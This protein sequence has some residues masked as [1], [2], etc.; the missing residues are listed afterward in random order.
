MSGA[1]QVWMRN[2]ANYEDQV[3]SALLRRGPC[4]S[5]SWQS[6][7]RNDTSNFPRDSGN[8]DFTVKESSVYS[9]PMSQCNW[10]RTF[11]VNKWVSTDAG[12]GLRSAGSSSGVLPRQSFSAPKTTAHVYARR[13]IRGQPDG[14]GPDATALPKARE[15]KSRTYWRRHF[16]H[17]YQQ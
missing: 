12:P 3:L 4:H 7:S 15:N 14:R 6:P 2:S 8:C 9:L 5:T 1:G 11:A 13:M 16:W 10:C 17:D